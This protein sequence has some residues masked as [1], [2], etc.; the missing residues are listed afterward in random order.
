MNR[1]MNTTFVSLVAASTLLVTFLLF[2]TTQIIT[3]NNPYQRV[4]HVK[5]MKIS[6][7]KDSNIT[8]EDLHMLTI[9]QTW[10]YNK[11]AADLVRN[12]SASLE[13]NNLFWTAELGKALKKGKC[14]LK[15]AKKI[16]KRACLPSNIVGRHKTCALVGNG[17]I[18]LG[19]N[20]GPE[21]D[22]YDYVARM[23]LPLVRGF[24][25][26]VG[27]RTNMTI[28][29]KETA[30]RLK[31]SAFLENRSRD[32]YES[33]LRA[34]EGSVLLIHSGSIH[35]LLSALRQYGSLSFV[36]LASKTMRF[37]TDHDKLNGINIITSTIAGMRFVKLPTLGL[38]T[39]I[40]LKT[41]CDRLHLYGFYPFQKDL[42]KR[43]IPY[44]YFPGDPL[45][46][47]IPNV[48]GN[49]NM[50]WE[51]NFHRELHRRGVYR[52]HLGACRVS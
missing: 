6:F 31:L 37:F 14:P 34:I 50:S 23:N 49:H 33:R 5:K 11:T 28:L 46:P 36:G 18:L 20:C 2:Y 4:S 44:H 39:V 1:T 17:G 15:E 40:T 48:N 16:P 41:I 8:D 29:N 24:E 21:I 22:S 42:N 45:R 10:R 9:P 30:K 27:K 26:D 35:A 43:T 7:D 32:V 12:A 13:I 25:K 52:M 51:Y 38:T 47:I 19:S 3:K